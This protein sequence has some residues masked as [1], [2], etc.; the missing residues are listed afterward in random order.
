MSVLNQNLQRA[1]TLVAA[2][3]ALTAIVLRVQGLLKLGWTALGSLAGFLSLGVLLFYLIMFTLFVARRTALETSVRPLHWLSALAGTFLPFLVNTEAVPDHRLALI[4][5]PIQVLGMVLML[6]AIATLGRGFGIIAARRSL[7]TSG[8]YAVVRHPLYAAEA[9]YLL[10]IVIS[11]LSAFNL[12][13]FAL[14]VAFQVQRLKEEEKLLGADRD[15]AAYKQ[16]VRFRLVP[17]LY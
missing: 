14:Q 4:A 10:S 1:L 6:T 5:A 3:L 9:V 2:A 16:R 7:R 8:L 12:L 11:S 17:G 13:V 15:Y